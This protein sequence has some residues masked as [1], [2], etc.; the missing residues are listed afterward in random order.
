MPT[1]IMSRSWISSS[2]VQD[3]A[4]VNAILAWKVHQN[5]A[6]DR[7]AADRTAFETKSGWSIPEASALA[8]RLSLEQTKPPSGIRSPYGF[9]VVDPD[10]GQLSANTNVSTRVD[11]ATELAR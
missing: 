10:V 8:A 4:A 3:T 9:A 7:R 5:V 2:D 6:I 1:S 11:A